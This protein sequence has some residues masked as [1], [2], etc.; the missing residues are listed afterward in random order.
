MVNPCF[1]QMIISQVLYMII[2]Y[3]RICVP[4]SFISNFRVPLPKFGFLPCGAF[5]FSLMVSHDIVSVEPFMSCH[6]S[7]PQVFTLSLVFHYPHLL[8]RE[9]QSLQSSQIVA[10]WTFLYYC[11]QRLSVICY[12]FCEKT[13]FSSKD[14]L[15]SISTFDDTLSSKARMLSSC[16]AFSLSKRA[17][18]FF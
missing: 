3:L 13:A 7:Y 9:A 14:N 1:K 12:L 11:Q 15:F 4:L 18:I 16:K 6:H 10:A 8:I 2:I 17:M 5:L